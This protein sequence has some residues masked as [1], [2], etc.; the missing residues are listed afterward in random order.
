MLNCKQ[1][2]RL[3]SE[4]QDRTLSWRERWG[5]RMHLW[6]CSNCRRFERQIRLMR[7]AFS[8]LSRRA[9]EDSA[10]GALSTD[11][12]ERIR[13]SLDDKGGPDAHG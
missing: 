11:A 7:R 9:E 3:V 8:M 1:A 5:L 10:S 4:G 12:R 13:K 6:M 2:S